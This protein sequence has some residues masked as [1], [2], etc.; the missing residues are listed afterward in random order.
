MGDCGC[1]SVRFRAAWHRHRG[2]A[3]CPDALAAE[4][5][6]HARWRQTRD[7]ELARAERRRT[8]A[9][10][11]AWSRLAAEYPQRFREI[12]LEELGEP[13]RVRT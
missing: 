13:E 8:A 7:P 3:P 10:F 9:R 5:E 6:Y 12:L 1:A 11:R 2:T 4:S